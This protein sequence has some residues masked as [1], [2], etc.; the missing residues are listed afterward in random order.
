[1]FQHRPSRRS[2]RRCVLSENAQLEYQPLEPRLA[3]ANIQVI[4]AG[5]TNQEIINLQI[6]GQVVRT[7]TNLGGNA[8]AGQY[9]TLAHTVNG[10]VT[11]DRVRVGFTN[12]FYDPA[13][14]ID[15]NVRVDAILIDGVRLET[16]LPTV[17][18]TGTWK[19]EDGVVAGFRQSEYLHSNGYFQYPGSGGNTGSVVQIRASGD[20]GG[21]QMELRI[22]GTTVSSFAVTAS[23]TDY[24]WRAPG[25]IAANQIRVAFTNDFYDQVNNVDRNLNVDHIA[26]DGIVHETEGPNVLSTG[27]W[28]PA[29]G[30]QPGFYES[31]T[32]HTIGYFQYDR[33]RSFGSIALQNSVIN[34][35]ETGGTANIVIVR[36]G[37]SDGTVTVDYRTVALTATTGTDFIARTGRA[38]FLPGETAKTISVTILDDLI[39]EGDEQ[40]SFTIDNVLGG[41]ALLAPRTA[42]ITI[43]DNDSIRA[44]GTGLLGEYFDNTG[45]TSRYINRVDTTV[46]FNWG[47]GA[48]ASG[49]GGD[50]FS[51][52]WTG[53]I[54]PRFSQTYTF[55]TRTDDG[56]RLW[57]NNQLIIDRW[58]NQP[59]TVHAG[60]IALQAGVFYDVRMEYYENVGQALASLSWSSPGQ[61]LEII[62]RS[63]LYPADPPPIT[64]GNEMRTQNLYSGLIAPTSMDFSPDG[65]NVYI[66]EQ[67]GVVRVARNGT[68]LTTPF[69]DFRDRVNGTRDR[70]LLDV[71]VHPDFAN[72]PYVYLIYTY[73]PPHVN[74]FAA[75][76]LAGPDGNGNRAGRVTRVTADAATNFTTIV[77][78]SEV[79]LI[80]N[81]STWS[82][83]NAFVNSTTNFSEPPAGILPGGGNLQ[84][85]IA[86]DSESH[87]V[88][89]VEFGNDGALY[90]S[91][92]DGASY[93]QVDP[94][95]A[96]VQDIGNLSGKILRVDPLTGKGLG[97][98]PFFNGNADANQSKV[99][100][101]GLR[102]PFRIALHPT[103]NK[104]Y[105]GDVGW[106][107]WEELNSAPAGTNFGWPWYEGG[108]GVSLKTGGYQDL[109]AAQIFYSSGQTVTSAFYAL[110]HA[111]SGINAIVMGDVYTG[112]VFPSQYRDNVFFGD[113]GQGVIR[114]VRFN[115]NGTV[116]QVQTFATGHQYVV[117]MVQGPDGNLY[118]VDLDDGIVG[119]WTFVEGAQNSFA[120]GVATP[121]TPAGN[122]PSNAALGNGVII[123]TIDSGL[124][125]THP[126]L[127]GKLWVNTTEIAGDGL[128]N[129]ANGLVDDVNG[130]D[131]VTGSGNLTDPFGHGSFMAGLI[132][133]SQLGQ[134]RGIAPDARLMSLRVLDNAGVGRSRDVAAAIRYAV[135]KGAKIIS[136]TLRVDGN[137]AAIRDAVDHARQRGVLLVV[138]AGTNASGDPSWLAG[139]SSGFENVLAIGAVDTSGTRLAE[140]SLVGN[141]GAVQLDAAGQAFGWT[142]TGTTTTYRGS[143]VAAAIASGT[144]AVA[145]SVNPDLNARQLRELLVASATIAGSG[146]DAAGTL[147]LNGAVALAARL[148]SVSF[149]Q[150]GARLNIFATTGDD[151]IRFGVQEQYVVI[152]GVGFEVPGRNLYTQVIIDGLGGTDRLTIK[153][154]EG[155]ADYGLLK[156]GY[157]SLTTATQFVRGAN[158]EQMVL[159]AGDGNTVV[160]F[161]DS[162]GDDQLAVADDLVSLLAGG[163]AFQAGNFRLNR[164]FAS[165]G[166]DTATFSGTDADERF[167]GRPGFSRLVRG[168]VVIQANQFDSVVAAMGGGF[169]DV[170]FEGSWRVERL[171]IRPNQ[172]RLTGDGFSV[173]VSQL[174]RTT[175][176]GHGGIDNMLMYDGPQMDIVNTQVLNTFLLGI[177][178]DH[179]AYS[180]ENSSIYSS[181]GLDR[182]TLTGTSQNESLVALP[183]IS[184]FS[185]D[186][187]ATEAFGFPI[188]L[189]RGAGGN[190]QANIQGAIGTDYFW[191]SPTMS[192]LNSGAFTL[193]TQQFA[194]TTFAGNGGTDFGTLVDNLGQDQLTLYRNRALLAGAGY[195][196]EIK[197]VSRLQAQS[198]VD[199][200]VDTIRFL[201]PELDYQ[202]EQFG[203]WQLLN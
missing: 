108:N 106:T 188:V 200:P 109:A 139:L 17:W 151:Q 40:F 101:Y 44:A 180:F 69:L 77:P 43:Q 145:L 146:S 143:S 111:A 192:V 36:T 47:T 185:G 105:V 114:N 74:G 199:E 112:S 138:A 78:N 166:N 58:I 12:D 186:T 2:T 176:Y 16:E 34:V 149:L 23:F 179:R 4:A 121:G 103:S 164:V 24:F 123:A 169:D 64:P 128:D 72:K 95:S 135:D 144:A 42:T 201:D 28:S 9:V 130:Y 113:L 86:T 37:G 49:M 60:T 54:E 59:E 61:S 56:V 50:T 127:A 80:G 168:P 102:N 110:N 67:R 100:Q 29:N 92:G 137:S 32:L 83:F 104:L 13:N 183:S 73:D 142:S 202:F 68:M 161:F 148:R 18:S 75:G 156:T 160:D 157:I 125:V 193:T 159:L 181:G 51:V 97:T 141:T 41:A 152:N 178:Y 45:F 203:D 87:T 134:L 91:I 119:R 21:E 197:N 118:F 155:G 172:G 122:L 165:Q 150:V 198:L 90:V 94:R 175:S 163:Y 167:L 81:N 120:A 124:N 99:W 5:V 62:P 20:V 79:V 88:G 39:V 177:G 71:A 31:E 26:I 136:L 174:E 147:S 76:S 27:T 10:S 82:N 85:F 11:P 46:N 154:A 173:D 25:T 93:N 3:L 66:A 30:V 33:L 14:S 153:G 131:F 196:V 96:R 107:Q 1:M 98:N 189:V 140:S 117:Q 8:Y 7:W 133:G 89:S 84:D 184:R 170:I 171:E 191:S 19:P 53:K 194:Q 187:F 116:A 22:D 38:T 6:D 65:S 182:A 70:G 129:D 63:Q 162:V 115:A 158:F 52:R 195:S 57:V 126:Q 35:A 190:D 55:Q 48:P 15:R 132:S